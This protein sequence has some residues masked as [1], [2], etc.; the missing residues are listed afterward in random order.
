MLPTRNDV[1]AVD[2]VLTNMLVAYKQTQDRFVAGQLFPEVPVKADSGTYYLLAQGDWFRDGMQA[3]PAGADFAFDEWAVSTTTYKTK[4]WALAKSIP[5]EIRAN[6]QLP[7]ELENLTVE[8]LGQ[9]SLIRKER[10][11]AADFMTTSVWTT[12]DNNSATDWDDFQ[13]GDPVNNVLTYYRTIDQLTGM[14][15][16]TLMVGQIVDMALR[17]HPDILDRIKYT[18]AATQAAVRSAMAALFGVDRYLVALAIYNSANPAQTASYSAIIDDDALLLH[19]APRPGIFTA[20][21]GYTFTW[22][23]GGGNGSI[24]QYYDNATHSTVVQ[25]KEEWDQKVIGA[26]LGALWLDIV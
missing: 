9:Q 7:M 5:D 17:I 1:Q 20:S 24:Y 11:F 12:T 15:P 3:R 8:W 23:G 10:G 14:Q 25:S 26:G 2:E 18:S 6:S 19:V 16:N 22:A 4:Q 13:N 21:G